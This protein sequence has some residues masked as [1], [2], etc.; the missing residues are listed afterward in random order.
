MAQADQP[1]HAQASDNEL[2]AAYQLSAGEPDDPVVEAI[3]AEIQK[4]G[5][6]L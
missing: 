3:L 5:L 2:L 4:R 1:D 6:N